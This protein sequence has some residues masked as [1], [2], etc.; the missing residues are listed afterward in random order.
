MKRK[1]G[2]PKT[3]ARSK[4]VWGARASARAG[5]RRPLR[6]PRRSQ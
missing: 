2:G 4:A 3:T 1:T 6:A 5:K